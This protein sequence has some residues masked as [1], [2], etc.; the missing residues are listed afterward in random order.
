M[1]KVF[2]KG[3]LPNLPKMCKFHNGDPKVMLGLLRRHRLKWEKASAEA[4]TGLGSYLTSILFI[5]NICFS[6]TETQCQILT[7]TENLYKKRN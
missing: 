4:R 6:Y 7:M 1:F 3:Q 5:Q 2:F